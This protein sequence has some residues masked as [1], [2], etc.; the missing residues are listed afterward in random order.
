MIVEAEERVVT[1]HPMQS[2]VKSTISGHWQRRREQRHL[3]WVSHPAA[4]HLQAVA[5]GVDVKK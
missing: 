4:L 2:S 5:S 3:P 1:Q